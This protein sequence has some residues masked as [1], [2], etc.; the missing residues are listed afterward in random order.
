MSE[1]Q[2]KTAPG[3]L[4][5][6][7]TLVNTQYGKGRRAHTE[8]SSPE[9]LRVWLVAHGLLA[10]DTPVT[11]GDLRRIFRLREELRSLLRANTKTEILA[12]PVEEL[13]YLASTAPLTVR[14]RHDGLPTL[15]P[16]IAGV[17]GAIARLV[18]IVFTAM[19]DG[20]WTRLKACCNDPCQK[21][22][23]DTSKNRSGMWCSMAGCGSRLKARTYRHR[24]TAHIEG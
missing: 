3:Q 4:A 16:D 9:Q 17:D 20:T 12:S 6:I 13:N 24:H 15:E 10:D 7:Q 8:L 14:F 11:E 22:F 1:E 21:A 18:G 5:L 23:Y 2:G 19:T